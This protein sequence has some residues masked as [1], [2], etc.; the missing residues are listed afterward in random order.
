MTRR[1]S[2]Y[3]I[4]LAAATLVLVTVVLGGGTGP[5]SGVAR[6]QEASSPPSGLVITGPS[7]VL[8]GEAAIYRA[9][10]GGAVEAYDW[11]LGEA[12]TT[13]PSPREPGVV[14]AAFTAAGPQVLRVVA[15]GPGGTAEASIPVQVDRADHAQLVTSPQVPV[16]GQPVRLLL[17]RR[18]EATSRPRY[19]AWQIAGIKPRSTRLTLRRGGAS[20]SQ[21]GR[22]SGPAGVRL[23]GA[24]PTATPRLTQTFPRAGAYPIRVSS[25]GADGREIITHTT[26]RVLPKPFT[27]ETFTEALDRLSGTAVLSCRTPG[28]AVPCPAIAT[29]G[30]GFGVRIPARFQNATPP[31]HV[32]NITD[33]PRYTPAPGFAPFVLPYP[34]PAEYLKPEAYDLEQGGVVATPKAGA[35]VAGPRATAAQQIGGCIVA[36][37]DVAQWT[38]GDT[39]QVP[40]LDPKAD[41]PDEILHTY[42]KDGRF[43]VSLVARQYVP[44]TSLVKEYL[45]LGGKTRVL[46]DAE[47][48]QFLQEGKLRAVF[49]RTSIQIDVR[50]PY[51]GDVRLQ[52]APA[53]AFVG[54]SWMS[55]PFNAKDSCFLIETDSVGGGSSAPPE[56]QRVYRLLNG[57]SLSL[58]GI[59]VQ[60]GT[61][62]GYVKVDPIQ[63]AVYA[64]AGDDLRLT[65]FEQRAGPSFF[66]DLGRTPRID[67]PSPEQDPDLGVHGSLLPDFG[68]ELSS[69][70]MYGFPAKGARVL[71]RKDAAATAKV[72]LDVPP[73]VPVGEISPLVKV[74]G[75]TAKVAAT[76]QPDFTIDLSGAELGSVR[77]EKFL[78]QHFPGQGWE[79]GGVVKYDSGNFEATLQADYKP[80]VEPFATQCAQLGKDRGPSGLRISDDGQFLHA[81]AALVAKIPLGPITVDCFG[82]FYTKQP[83][84]LRGL[85]SGDVLTVFGFDG[86]VQVSR[87]QA[88]QKLVG[89]PQSGAPDGAAYT[90][91]Q[92]ETWVN[93]R[94]AVDLL[95]VLQLAEAG[96]DLHAGADLLNISAF[97]RIPE[98]FFGP[99]RIAGRVDGLIVVKPKDKA[100]FQ[101]TGD[102][103]LA[104]GSCPAC[105]TVKAIVSS[106]GVGACA[107]V[108]LLSGGF[109]YRW[110]GS[111]RLNLFGGCDFGKFQPISV[112]TSALP[113]S[114]E[115]LA[116]S[117]QSTLARGRTRTFRVGARSRG[118]SLRLTGAGEEPPR[119]LITG[120]GGRTYRTPDAFKS[121]SGA[122]PYGFARLPGPGRSSVGVLV[123]KGG[124]QPMPA[125]AGPLR[126][127]SA[128]G[129][130]DLSP[131]TQTFT[132]PG[133]TVVT[134][135]APA[136]GR[137]TVSALPGSPAIA[138]LARADRLPERRIAATTVV[139]N[140]RRV[141]DF[142]VSPVPGQTVDFYERGDGVG[143]LIARAGAPKKQGG[144]LRAVEDVRPLPEGHGL[145]GR[146]TV[147]AVISQDGVPIKEVVLP[148]AAYTAPGPPAVPRPG[149]VTVQQ[150]AREVKVCW[151]RVDDAV[152]YD[153]T[154]RTPATGRTERFRLAPPH[155]V[156]RPCKIAAGYYGDSATTAQVAAI[157]RYGQT[158]TPAFRK[159]APR[160]V[161]SRP[162]LLGP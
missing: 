86:C 159:V 74:G 2:S 58:N 97:G 129:P 57:A 110:S 94:V 63:D 47:K 26:I 85:F 23:A 72:V 104:F 6:A 148:K 10:V 122:S 113:G 65:L 101:F 20:A 49:V 7:R 147:T 137:W 161:V 116:G 87:M 90:A 13:E 38:F 98:T 39:V 25:V 33:L 30:S 108:L 76:G 14:T 80:Q 114:A 21:A 119:V 144:V 115:L 8:V 34:N 71:L 24:Q 52:E 44:T 32:C 78:L 51:C 131:R 29:E 151:N 121:G 143:R 95:G 53:R 126:R 120:P 59:N 11:S 84:V 4:A 152:A 9:T 67:V 106:K 31:M 128:A 41:L 68:G 96:F 92:P 27:P 46:S 132:S 150:A 105:A 70:K 157:T 28:L 18:G 156:A 139:R 66:V 155:T 75:G 77:V 55:D 73:G 100:G 123:S 160:N 103:Q 88:G 109:I 140:G 17:Q 149:R 36:P 112:T 82:A 43:T 62:S 145:P 93:A 81:G 64:T 127:P 42:M 138:G 133:T 130:A 60:P 89:C 22:P 45:N 54:T 158:R 102:V 124:A 142:A 134:L 61:G 146:R 117:A 16:A 19:F 83:F 99:F 48:A 69:G 125:P 141:L 1:P 136:R 154:L 50:K 135:E 12:G 40:P 162:F 37:A 91:K 107:D 3:A 111:E 153:V 35:S 15:R 79:G 5:V 56:E 118:V